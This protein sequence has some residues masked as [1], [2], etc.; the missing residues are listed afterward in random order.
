MSGYSERGWNKPKK[1]DY[2]PCGKVTAIL[3][4]SISEIWSKNGH[5]CNNCGKYLTW[6]KNRINSLQSL[7]FSSFWFFPQQLLSLYLSPLTSHSTP[8]I[9]DTIWWWTISTG[10]QK[11]YLS[12][13][14]TRSCSILEFFSFTFFSSSWIYF[15]KFLIPL[16]SSRTNRS[17]FLP[18][19]T[20]I[21]SNILIIAGLL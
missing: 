12:P 3:L 13:I 8:S 11:R 19:S 7:L 4:I 5:D 15:A 6:N 21:V 18:L 9:T 10:P 14:S 20:L 16:V 2:C 1:H 17:N